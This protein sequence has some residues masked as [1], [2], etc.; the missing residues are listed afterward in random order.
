MK[1]RICKKTNRDENGKPVPTYFVQKEVEKTKGIFKKRKVKE[2]ETC[3]Y[4]KY[5]STT[6]SS[7]FIPYEVSTLK[8]ARQ[9]KRWLREPTTEDLLFQVVK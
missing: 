3:G 8:K 7:Y 1:L 5:V 6:I 2:W 4:H 9:L